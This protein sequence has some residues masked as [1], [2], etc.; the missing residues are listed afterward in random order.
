MI[1][2]E[3]NLADCE[4][5]DNLL[6]KL[7]RYESEYNSNISSEY[8]VRDNYVERIETE[9]QKAFVAVD[10]DIIVGYL[11]G[12][13]YQIP[14]LFIRPVA[15]LDALYVEEKYRR[16]GIAKKLFNEFRKFALKNGACNIELKVLSNNENALSL[17]KELGFC[18]NIDYMSLTL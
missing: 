8:I 13:I 14:K 4:H 15:F 3:A 18:R 5:L 1:I 7:I 2:R 17:Y 10:E 9:G 12:F 6:T 11:Y 16:T